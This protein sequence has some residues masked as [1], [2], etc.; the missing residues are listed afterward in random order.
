ME[1]SSA[2]NTDSQL[3]MAQLVERV[4]SLLAQAD[5]DVSSYSGHIV[6]GLGQPLQSLESAGKTLSSSNIVLEGLGGWMGGCRWSSPEL[7]LC[8][9]LP[10]SPMLQTNSTYRIEV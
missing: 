4:R 1:H 5:L 2:Y 9:V 8:K 7:I 10:S 3:S 6:L